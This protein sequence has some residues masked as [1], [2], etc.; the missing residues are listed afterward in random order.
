VPRT[1]ACGSR[2][3]QGKDVA[4][5]LALLRVDQSGL[6]FASLGDSRE[7]RPGQLVV[8]IG[9]P[10]GFAHTVSA[11]VVSALGR[12]LTAKNGRMVRRRPSTVPILLTY[13]D[14]P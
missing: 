7:L 2:A 14:T 12:S 3:A 11:G 9:N 1:R 13:S 10:L 5:D 4:T 6:P 8:A